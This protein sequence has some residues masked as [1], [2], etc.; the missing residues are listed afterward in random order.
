[1]YFYKNRIKIYLNR[2]WLKLLILLL[3]LKVV[4]NKLKWRKRTQNHLQVNK[5]IVEV[6]GVTK[7]S[8]VNKM[9]TK[10]QVWRKQYQTQKVLQDL[11]ADIYKDRVIWLMRSMKDNEREFY[12]KESMNI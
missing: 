5:K 6:F 11:E 10:Y 8:K 2:K 1:M 9:N 3:L 7:R 4:K 12:V